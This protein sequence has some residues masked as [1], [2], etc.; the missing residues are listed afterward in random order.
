MAL[1]LFCSC[2]L[3]SPPPFLFLSLSCSRSLTLAL[4]NEKKSPE[5]R[6][7][8]SCSAHSTCPQ[9]KS[10]LNA[11][12]AQI[13]HCYWHL[14]SFSRYSSLC[15]STPEALC[16]CTAYPNW[17]SFSPTLFILSSFAFPHLFL[18]ASA[19]KNQ[20]EMWLWEWDYLWM[21][22]AVMV[23]R[24]KSLL[25]VWGAVLHNILLLLLQNIL[26]YM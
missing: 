21:H 2:P 6:L 13:D 10:S 4:M 9:F 15:C 24:N 5:T 11:L 25:F 26:H 16:L 18:L 3:V 1:C 23:C 7:V 12:R 8:S 20:H 14:H 19:E 17:S 22:D